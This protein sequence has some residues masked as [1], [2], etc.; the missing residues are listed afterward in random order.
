MMRWMRR[1]DVS[2]VTAD[3]KMEADLKLDIQSTGMPSDTYDVIICNHVLEHVDDYKV[4]LNEFNRI[5]APGGFFIC[6][7]P[8]DPKVDI[9]DEDSSVK[10][11]EDRLKFYGQKDHRRVFGMNADKILVKA[12][13]KV[14]RIKENSC[15]EIIYPI[16]GPAD[17]D[18]NVLFWCKKDQQQRKL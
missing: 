13:F 18:M 7:F 1:N 16:I 10:L 8:M 12:G 3:K 6:S 4:A 17:Y 11:A 14:K 15:P 5:L 2:C 9:V